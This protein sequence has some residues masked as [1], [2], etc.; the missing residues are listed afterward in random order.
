MTALS[1]LVKQWP[2]CLPHCD[3]P[4][5]LLVF[6]VSGRDLLSHL[7]KRLVFVCRRRH[8]GRPYSLAHLVRTS[9]LSSSMTGSGSS[10]SRPNGPRPSDAGPR[11]AVEM[12]SCICRLVGN[13][14]EHRD[15]DAPHFPET[16]VIVDDL[17]EIPQC[18][19]TLPIVS[20]LST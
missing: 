20:D 1:V 4:S 15:D 2:R 18:A 16:K 7:A 5:L 19:L 9:P 8:V 14:V 3:G 6:S 17:L 13:G 10:G 12:T 11:C